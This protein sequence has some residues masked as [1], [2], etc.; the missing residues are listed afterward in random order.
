MHEAQ[1]SG[2]RAWCL[3]RRRSGNLCACRISPVLGWILNTFSFFVSLWLSMVGLQ[4]LTFQAFCFLVW[5]T[6]T[7]AQ[8]GG[9]GFLGIMQD[10]LHI[11]RSRASS[12]MK[13]DG[14]GRKKAQRSPTAESSDFVEISLPIDIQ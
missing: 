11:W 6:L 7:R 14:T 8:A 13:S 9:L 10:L 5:R 12:D 3:S 1:E 2:V 4:L